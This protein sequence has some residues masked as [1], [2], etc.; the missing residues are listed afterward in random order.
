MLNSS[1]S[2]FEVV[3]MMV[4]ASRTGPV[5]PEVIDDLFR[6]TDEAASEARHQSFDHASINEY[7]SLLPRY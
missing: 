6:R 7:S 3:T 1:A 4:S 5:S 2:K